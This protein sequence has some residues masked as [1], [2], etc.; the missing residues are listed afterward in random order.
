MFERNLHQPVNGRFVES[1]RQQFHHPAGGLNKP[2]ILVS[3]IER[4]IVVELRASSFGESP[5]M[6]IFR[7]DIRQPSVHK[8][9]FDERS[10]DNAHLLATLRGVMTMD[11]GA[12]L[13]FG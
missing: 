9:A 5:A 8:P 10:I 11:Q 13:R 1:E 12:F 6:L 2:R 7:I 3:Q 4:A